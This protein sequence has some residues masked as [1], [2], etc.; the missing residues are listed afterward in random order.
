V[1]SYVAVSHQ[2]INS[3]STS[4]VPSS[5]QPQFSDIGGAIVPGQLPSI[6]NLSV[7]GNNSGGTAVPSPLSASNVLDMIGSV[8]GDILYR[9]SA[10]WNILA[11][12]TNGFI[13]ATGGASANPSWINPSS[14]GTV[15]QVIA[16]A[17]ISVSSPSTCTTTCTIALGT[18]TAGSVMANITGGAAVPIANT[19]SSILDLIGSAAGD[20]LYRTSGSGWSVLAPGTNGQVLT[21]GA[22]T[23]SWSNAGTLTNVTIAAGTGISVTG[24]C[25][26]STSGTCTIAENLSRITNSL[27]SNVSLNNTSNY[28]DGPSVAQGTSGTWFASGSVLLTDTAGAAAFFCKLWDGTTI[29]A[30]AGGNVSAANVRT[31]ISLSG[32]LNSPAAN[33]RISCI[34]PSSTSGVINFNNTGNS[35]DSTITAIRLQ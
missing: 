3:I 30:S 17:G 27:S 14:G 6:S 31:Q 16:G 34:D 8:Q 24:T 25:N 9:G 26:I 23:P 29:I 19:P 33:I 2:W 20:I 32:I 1:E 11:P 15:T 28:F 35:K 12:G 13:L 7:L 10:G 4:G 18:I 21:Q 22:S 5:T